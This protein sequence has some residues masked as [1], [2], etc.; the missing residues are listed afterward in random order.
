[1]RQALIATPSEFEV[2]E[3]PRPTLQGPDEAIVRTAACGICSGDL[4]EWYMR[5]KV[6]T[7]LGH[8]VVGYAVD[9]GSALNEMGR[10]NDVS[11][12]EAGHAVGF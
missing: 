5:R 12:P 11:D 4:M 7:V 2:Q 1:M 9:V 6:G 3:V 8:E 10:T